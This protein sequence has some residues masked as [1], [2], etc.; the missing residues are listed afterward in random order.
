MKKVLL[1]GGGS[2]GHICPLLP[3][4][5][6]FSRKNITCEL[7]VSSSALDRQIIRG[8]FPSTQTYFLAT[9]KIRRYWS[10]KNLLAPFKICRSIFAAFLLLKKI[11]PDVVFLKGGFVCFPVLMAT[12]LC[13]A[14]SSKKIIIFSHESDFS[15]GFVTRLAQKFARKH[16][17]NFGSPSCP[18]FYSTAKF[19]RKKSKFLLPRLLIM[20]GSQGSKNI[21]TL[22]A[23]NFKSLCDNYLVTL[24]TGE[25][26]PQTVK[27][28][29]LQIYPSLPA[30]KLSLLIANSQAI[31]S[32]AGANSLLEIIYYS[33]P[34]L[35][36]PLSSAARNHQTENAKFFAKKNLCQIYSPEGRKNLLLCL[37][38]IQNS[39][40]IQKA[41]K[42]YKL[43][44]SAPEIALE[45]IKHLEIKPT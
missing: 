1:V 30:K 29:N 9:D 26:N 42:N 19:S 37:R 7:L 31:I 33:V 13:N 45:I 43:T 41:L 32:R 40:T 28:K 34:S 27:H 8:N 14:V 24:V 10:I 2:G 6:E 44:N 23:K 38:S 25:K 22:F 11:C 16:F 3:L 4:Q 5:R 36:L 17:S 39:K 18:L 12:V 35:I 20:G 21:N 15:P